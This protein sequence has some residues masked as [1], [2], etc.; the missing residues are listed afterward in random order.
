MWLTRSKCDVTRVILMHEVKT[1]ISLFIEIPLNS[2]FSHFS[3]SFKFYD[4]FPRDGFYKTVMMYANDRELSAHIVDTAMNTH[5]SRVPFFI[6]LLPGTIISK[7]SISMSMMDMPLSLLFLFFVSWVIVRK[8]DNLEIVCR[9]YLSESSWH[10]PWCGKRRGS[11][12][13]VARRSGTV[14]PFMDRK[15]DFSCR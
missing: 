14:S 6:V 10:L 9:I 8:M 1:M 2:A 7:I 13:H 15:G 4:W 3:E 5:F 11:L 12:S